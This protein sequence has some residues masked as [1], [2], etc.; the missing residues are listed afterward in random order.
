[1]LVELAVHVHMLHTGAP[2][3]PLFPTHHE[4]RPADLQDRGLTKGLCETQRRPLSSPASEASGTVV[5]LGLLLMSVSGCAEGA[6]RRCGQRKGFI[7]VRSRVIFGC[8]VSTKTAKLESTEIQEPNCRG[9]IRPSC[10]GLFEG[11]LCCVSVAEKFN[12]TRNLCV[13]ISLKRWLGW[14]PRFFGFLLM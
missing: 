6:A 7:S 4:V 12:L 9:R 1:M 11:L 13:Q 2:V 5:F 10:E 8:P 14:A 3:S